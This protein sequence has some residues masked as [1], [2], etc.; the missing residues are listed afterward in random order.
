MRAFSHESNGETQLLGRQRPNQHGRPP[1]T[2]AINHSVLLPPRHH[3]QLLSRRKAPYQCPLFK[4]VLIVLQF[5][6][7]DITSE[8]ERQGEREYPGEKELVGRFP[9]RLYCL[10]AYLSSWIRANDNRPV[11]CPLG[12]K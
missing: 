6:V 9:I 3:A 4:L 12:Y 1:R 11:N 8:R 10:R 2:T 7:N 5:S